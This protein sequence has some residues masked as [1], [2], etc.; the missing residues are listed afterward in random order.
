MK[1][2]GYPDW[3]LWAYQKGFV[4]WLSIA[5]LFGFS[6]LGVVLH[7]D[8]S[9]RDTEQRIHQ[10]LIRVGEDLQD[11]ED[12]QTQELQEIRDELDAIRR[13]LKEMREGK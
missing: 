8:D 13:E 12:E 11:G 3:F 6:L 1:E 2:N 10:D 7:L 9:V 4:F 5:A